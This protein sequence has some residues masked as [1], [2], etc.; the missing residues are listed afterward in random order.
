MDALAE[1][2]DGLRDAPKHAG[3]YEHHAGAAG[4]LDHGHRIIL[5]PAVGPPFRVNACHPELLSGC[6]LDSLRV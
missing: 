1:V 6:K 4:Q 5:L 3:A 2:D